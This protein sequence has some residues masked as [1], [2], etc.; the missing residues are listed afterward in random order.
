MGP[1]SRDNPP[2]ATTTKSDIR[3]RGKA[4]AQQPSVLIRRARLSAKSQIVNLLDHLA[5]WRRNP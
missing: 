5:L 3:R 2:T 4:Q 1:I